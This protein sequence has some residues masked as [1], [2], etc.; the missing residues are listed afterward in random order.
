MITPARLEVAKK[1]FLS[2]FE[3]QSTK[4]CSSRAILPSIVTA[5]SSIILIPGLS[6][7]FL[8][9]EPAGGVS[10]STNWLVL[11]ALGVLVVVTLP[12]TLMYVPKGVN[13]RVYVV[14]AVVEAERYAHG[15]R[16]VTAI[17]AAY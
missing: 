3:L 15:T 13:H 2:S 8:Q 17:S 1:S 10:L 12:L 11:A 5:A 4:W 7:R 14:A 16:H 9:R 6:F